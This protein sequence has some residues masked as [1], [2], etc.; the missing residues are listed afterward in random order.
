MFLV[1]RI[2]CGLRRGSAA[3]AMVQ[4]RIAQLP[5]A[6]SRNRAIAQSRNV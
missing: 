6:Q 4:S 5:I 1:A 2:A 3:T